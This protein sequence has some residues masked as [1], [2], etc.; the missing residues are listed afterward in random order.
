MLER[1]FFDGTNLGVPDVQERQA[2]RA[3]RT[4]PGIIQTLNVIC[5]RMCKESC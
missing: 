4:A 5:V 1:L 2:L 3:P